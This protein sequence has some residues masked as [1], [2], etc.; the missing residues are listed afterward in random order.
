MVDL[1]EI[2]FSPMVNYNF[3]LRVDGIFDL[4]CKSIHSFTQENEYEYIQEGGLND[5]VHI[6]RKSVSKPFTFTVERYVGI[7]FYDP[8][9]NGV[10]LKL[11]IILLVNKYVNNFS[12]INRTYVFNGCIVMSKEYGEL[13]S[14]KSGLLTENTVIAYRELYVV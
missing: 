10:E 7:D 3:V 1:K 5:Y 6:R 14:E 8:L 2:F 4:P 12:I 11:P 9:K 13:N